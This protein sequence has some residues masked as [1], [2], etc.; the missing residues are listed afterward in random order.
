MDHRVTERKGHDAEQG[1]GFRD[2]PKPNPARA[3]HHA[4]NGA[5]PGAAAGF[6]ESSRRIAAA[7]LT[8]L[9]ATPS[10][11]PALTAG[12]ALAALLLAIAI[13]VA[14]PDR[15]EAQSQSGLRQPILVS[16]AG[17]TVSLSLSANRAAQAF[18]TGGSRDYTLDSITLHGSGFCSSC[19]NTATL[20]RGS[21]TGSAITQFNA[22]VGNSGAT[23][24]LTPTGATRLN[25]NTTYFIVTANN[26]GSSAIWATTSSDNE[27]ANP[28][29]AWSIADGSELYNTGRGAWRPLTT[30]RQITVRGYAGLTATNYPAAGKP[31][32]SGTNRV[33]YVMTASR[34]SVRDPDGPFGPFTVSYQWIRVDGTT[35]TDI[36]GATTQYY[37]LTGADVGKTIRVRA[38]FTDGEGNLEARKSGSTSKVTARVL[39]AF[40]HCDST[41]ADEVWCGTA[42]VTTMGDSL[43]GF[44][45]SLNKGSVDPDAFTAGG[46]DFIVNHIYQAEQ[47]FGF[48]MQELTGS[49][50]DGCLHDRI[51]GG[52][53]RLTVGTGDSARTFDFNIERGPV[54]HWQWVPKGR[55]WAANDSVKVKLERV[56]ST[57]GSTR[58]DKPVVSAAPL[59]TGGDGAIAVSWTRVGRVCGLDTTGYRLQVSADG[60]RWRT[61]WVQNNE[62][63]LSY[64]HQGLLPDSRRYYRVEALNWSQ[65]S[66]FGAPAS[67]ETAGSNRGV[68]GRTEAVRAVIMDA[69][70]NVI[71]CR[72]VTGTHLLAITS[73]SIGDDRLETTGLRAGDFAGLAGL[74]TLSLRNSGLSALPAGVFDGLTALTRLDLAVNSLTTVPAGVFD[75]LTALTNLNMARNSLTALPAGVFD[76]LTA[77]TRLD[78]Q[79]NELASLPDGLFENQ[80]Q[81]DNWNLGGNPGNPFTKANAGADRT[82]APGATVTLSGSTTGPWGSNVVWWWSQRDREGSFTI[83]SNPVTLTGRSTATASF[84]APSTAAS[85]YFRLAVWG[86]GEGQS[87]QGL[88]WVTIT[89]ESS[90]RQAPN[91]PAAGA[92]TI[93]GTAQAGRTLTASAAGV[94]DADGLDNAKYAYQWLADDA[95]ISGAAGAAYTV[96]DGDVGKTI[97]VRV[98]FDDDQGNAE[99]RTSAATATVI[100][101]TLDVDSA[102]V[103]GSTLAINYKATLDDG[104][105]IPTGAFSVNVAGGSRSVSSVSIAGSTV[106]LTLASEVTSGQTVTVS[107]T[108]PS[109]SDFIRD[110][111]GRA[112][113]SFT[114]YNVTNTTARSAVPKAAFTANV[115]GEPSTHDG[116]AAFT[117]ELHLTEEPAEGFSY[118]TMRDHAFNVTN[119]DVKKAK[120]NDAGKNRK[121]IITVA[122][123]GDVDVAI[124]LPATTDCS[125]QG[126]ICTQD[127]RML[128]ERVSFTV[129]GPNSSRSQESNANSLATGAPTITG[130]AQVGESLTAATADIRDSDGLTNVSYGYQWV[131]NDGAN[132]AD[133][134]GATG[135]SYT[136]VEADEGRTVKVRVSFSDDAGNRETLTS[137]ATGTVAAAPAPLTAGFHETPSSH[138]GSAAFTFELRFSEEFPVSF[139]TLRDHAFNVTNGDVKKAK[140][141]DT[142]KNRKWIITVEPTGNGDVTVVLPLTTD[143]E[144]DGAICAADGR[145]LSNRSGLTVNGPDG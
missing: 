72:H 36:A 56:S 37:T 115:H 9:A 128:S 88:D 124:T 66:G 145:M 102:T 59:T 62:D 8:R 1:R 34:G 127:G 21:R 95:E 35:E 53:Y 19:V 63:F 129:P 79:S 123:S 68:C 67:A 81:A 136:L 26:F 80:T 41:D 131:R 97:K 90:M 73:L 5:T 69:I 86:K 113:E 116:S 132:D 143:C 74:R 3:N 6:F 39:T 12:F 27:D 17:Q 47:F 109:G 91:N 75:D 118:R 76:D 144:A 42:R 138:D 61:L 108:R 94:T 57:G 141:K 23:L 93:T 45:R 104:V 64:T 85:L 119:G 11:R 105:T 100:A 29:A 7:L 49:V 71:D 31:V 117:F 48:S 135:S 13:L 54:R 50:D 103:S 130:T 126:A 18:T 52:S 55:K 140:R 70:P 65:A 22:V 16:N 25:A 32:I 78:L 134:G 15:A 43:V 107:Y 99:S 111:G 110:T 20:R 142:G 121:W 33:G 51:G 139:R 24:A 60:E 112:A 2:I 120:R 89:V 46:H 28:A 133:I 122:P 38:S 83:P 77:L 125:A 106:S 87:Q 10:H 30:S 114:D 98:D 82:V 4:P 96:A 58:Q 101:A 137:A 92:P 14:V 44:A 84:T 40:S